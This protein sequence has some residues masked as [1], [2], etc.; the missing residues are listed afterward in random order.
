MAGH[1]QARTEA[2]AQAKWLAE[3]AELRRQGRQAEAEASLAAFRRHY[4]HAAA[5]PLR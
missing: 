2:D 4:P 1:E 3:I 5:D